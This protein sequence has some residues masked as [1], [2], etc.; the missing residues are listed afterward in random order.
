MRFTLIIAAISTVAY[1]GVV[2]VLNEPSVY[3]QASPPAPLAQ[4][5]L[6]PTSY[7][8]VQQSSAYRRRQLLETITNNGQ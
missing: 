7:G 4:P 5:S 3:E 1:A 8:E 2:Q 6:A